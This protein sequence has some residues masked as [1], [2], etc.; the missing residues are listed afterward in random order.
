M[1]T[2]GPG[3]P[4]EWTEFGMSALSDEQTLRRSMSAEAVAARGA[5]A[6]WGWHK[7]DGNKFISWQATQY[8]TELFLAPAEAVR[9]RPASALATFSSLAQE[10]SA[11]QW[12]QAEGYRYAY[13]AARRRKWHRSAMLLWTLNEPWPNAAHGCIIDYR[14]LPKHAW[15]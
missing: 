12:L 8:Y 9:Q 7:G 11:S 2:G 5:S 1:R 10:V 15:G 4:F 6:E 14:G 3:D 13:Q